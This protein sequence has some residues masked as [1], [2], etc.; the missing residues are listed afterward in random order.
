MTLGELEAA[1]L[2]AK[3][4]GC[5]ASTSIQVHLS[6]ER[7]NIIVKIETSGYEPFYTRRNG[8]P[9]AKLTAQPPF[10]KEQFAS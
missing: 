1:I 4:Q 9:I 8:I 6:Q 2:Q 3:I 10:Y 7:K 5:D